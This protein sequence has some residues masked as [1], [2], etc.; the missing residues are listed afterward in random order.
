[1]NLIEDS[2]RIAVVEIDGYEWHM[3]S[4]EYHIMQ[5]RQF[6]FWPYDLKRLNPQLHSCARCAN[7]PLDFCHT[8]ERKAP[9]PNVDV[10]NIP[11]DRACHCFSWSRAAPFY[12]VSDCERGRWK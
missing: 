12:D 7:R 5:R 6:H 2:G 9:P 11:H 3:S 10:W 1:M 4:E 8:K